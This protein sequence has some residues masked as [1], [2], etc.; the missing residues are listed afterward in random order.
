MSFLPRV[1]LVHALIDPRAWSHERKGSDLL[2]AEFSGGVPAVFHQVDRVVQQGH[3]AKETV[4]RPCAI[5]R[6]W[7]STELTKPQSLQ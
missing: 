3:L 6:V 7:H 1:R 2:L 5:V 4:E